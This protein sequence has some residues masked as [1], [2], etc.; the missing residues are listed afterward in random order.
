M[1]N[2]SEQGGLCSN[3]GSVD[4]KYPRQARVQ[5]FRIKKKPAVR[6]LLTAGVA[7][8]AR[9]ERTA[10]RLGGERSILLSYGDIYIYVPIIL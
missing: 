1:K 9:F 8:P 7:S 2:K 5:N 3:F 4:K 10:F 6:D